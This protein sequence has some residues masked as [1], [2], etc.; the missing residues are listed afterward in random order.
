ML[1]AGHRNAILEL[2]HQTDT[3]DLAI[4]RGG[5]ALI[6]F[7]QENARVPVIAHAKGGCHLY[8]DGGADVEMAVRLAVN[9]KLQ[10]P[11]VCNAIECLRVDASDAERMLPPIPRALVAGG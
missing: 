10:R 6:R 9:A 3:V 1:P 5:E 7:V 11:G 8:V 2:L 4:P